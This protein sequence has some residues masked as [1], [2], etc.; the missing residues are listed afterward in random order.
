MGIP[1]NIGN[2]ALPPPGIDLP[3]GPEVEIPLEEI[4]E[5][6]TP[7]GLGDIDSAIE[8]LS[9]QDAL[10][11]L[12]NL[13]TPQ[14]SLP[15][16]LI[17]EGT[18]ENLLGS[19]MQFI[20]PLT[21]RIG[22]ESQVFL[23]EHLSTLSPDLQN[24]LIAASLLSDGQTAEELTQG[25]SMNPDTALTQAALED[26]IEN[27]LG[28]NSAQQDELQYVQNYMESL[29][30]THASLSILISQMTQET[31]N[32]II[33]ALFEDAH[34]AQEAI[35]DMLEEEAIQD[36][37]SRYDDLPEIAFFGLNDWQ[38][39][40]ASI[41]TVAS[42]PALLNT[43]HAYSFLALPLLAQAFRENPDIL[44]NL[45]KGT[46]LAQFGAIAIAWAA[47][48]VGA[49]GSAGMNP[50]QAIAAALTVF[51]AASAAGSAHPGEWAA[52]RQEFLSSLPTALQ[53]VA[54]QA[55]MDAGQLAAQS[56][57]GLMM[58]LL[59]QLLAG[60]SAQRGEQPSPTLGSFAGAE[61]SEEL[62]VTKDPQEAI[63]NMQKALGNLENS[64]GGMQG[65]A[66]QALRRDPEIFQNF[67]QLG[68]AIQ[69]ALLLS[70]HLQ[71]GHVALDQSIQGAIFAA[72][73]QLDPAFAGGQRQA[74]VLAG[75]QAAI[76]EI[77]RQ[78]SSFFYTLESFGNQ[79]PSAF[80]GMTL[81]S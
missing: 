69:Q 24:L 48:M 81:K 38:I 23:G 31:S 49:E 62:L 34:E 26:A 39:V 51:L 79:I 63:N 78:W 30:T 29:S 16:D 75:M 19:Y 6:E 45:G 36:L 42:S 67:L 74:E 43:F 72:L 3:L 54:T 33:D 70:T 27:F 32:T 12:P 56:L 4:L 8:S 28:L 7:A 14:L 25:L 20:E 59:Q 9:S 17:L 61:V 37:L 15:S 76:R 22:G 5:A 60:T 35:S 44:K 10:G 66:P 73:A 53:S 13:E 21:E 77:N 18:G 11:L 50:D 46:N 40:L 57:Q 55:G 52:A 68:E 80:N 41:V 65:Q 58:S 47:G 71:H 2:Q 64:L 1:E